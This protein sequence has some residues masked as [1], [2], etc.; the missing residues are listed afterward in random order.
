MFSV[1]L[2]LGCREI[3]IT[4][5]KIYKKA[6]IFFFFFMWAIY[7][8]IQNSLRTLQKVVI[9]LWQRKENYLTSICVKLLVHMGEKVI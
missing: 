2:R 1:V 7:W 8:N 3:K 6:D 5:A 9:T 4:Q